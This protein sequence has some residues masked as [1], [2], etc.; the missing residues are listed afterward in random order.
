MARIASTVLVV[1]L[2]AATAAAFVHGRAGDIAAERC[3]EEGMT[4][5]DLAEALPVAIERIR[6]G[7][8]SSAS[9]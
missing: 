4:A 6:G 1:A 8:V 3:G 9:S 7:G 2:L 5:G